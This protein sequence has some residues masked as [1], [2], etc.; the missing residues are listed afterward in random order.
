MTENKQTEDKIPAAEAP[1]DM[2]QTADAKAEADG[3]VE[4]SQ[5]D[6]DAVAGGYPLGWCGPAGR[7]PSL[8]P[9]P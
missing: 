1:Q 2:V 4:L 7:S 9:D 8:R 6:L 5:D 3:T